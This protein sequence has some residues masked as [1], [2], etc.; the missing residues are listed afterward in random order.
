M[1]VIY[2]LVIVFFISGCDSEV[3][4]SVQMRNN[5]AYLQNSDEPFTGRYIT[6]FETG[7][8]KFEQNLK[9]GKL[10]GLS[11]EWYENGQKKSEQNFTD[12]QAD[13]LFTTWYANGQKSSETYYKDGKINGISRKWTYPLGNG[14]TTGP[15]EM[16][17]G[18]YRD[19]KKNGSVIV[20]LDG[21]KIREENYKD[22]KFDGLFAEWSDGQLKI[23]KN[24]KDGKKDGVFIFIDG[25]ASAIDD[26]KY[27]ENYKN[28]KLNGLSTIWW[29]NGQKKSEQNF[30]DGQADGLFT[31]WYKSGQKESE[32]H[33]KDGTENGL[34][35][36]W[37]EN[38]Q[39]IYEENYKDGKIDESSTHVE[40][41]NQSATTDVLTTSGA[42]KVQ[43]EANQTP[44]LPLFKENESYATIR[45]KMIDSGWTPFH[46]ENADACLEGD[47][48]CEGRPEMESCAGTGMANCKFLWKKNEKITAICTAGEDAAFDRICN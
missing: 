36:M 30:K 34:S 16:T 21:Q 48:R 35:T 4:N 31:M 44:D 40:V 13:G 20:T 7:Q 22:D 9:D 11:T 15:L 6:Y 10:D 38:G 19:G 3:T 24:Y 12:G 47:L 17:E 8:K 33:F 43:K 41:A 25:S 28:D 23:E 29:G 32:K 45:T 39:K 42:A 2:F 14:R 5:I 27:E 1:K 18:N 26:S 46:S 37:G